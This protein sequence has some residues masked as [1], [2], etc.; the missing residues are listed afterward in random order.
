MKHE[1][2]RRTRAKTPV[3]RIGQLEEKICMEMRDVDPA[4]MLAKQYQEEL[5]SR[6]ITPCPSVHTPATHQNSL[7]RRE[8]HRLQVA[9]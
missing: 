5:P 7:R 6:G 4:Q 3:F 8:W 1:E 2:H 9:S